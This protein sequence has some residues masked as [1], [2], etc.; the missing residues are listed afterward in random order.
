MPRPELV[1]AL[2]FQTGAEALDMARALS[3]LAA[4]GQPA[5]G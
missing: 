1:V 2:D 5:C 3:S 4:P